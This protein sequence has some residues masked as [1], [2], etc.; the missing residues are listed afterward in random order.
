MSLAVSSFIGLWSGLPAYSAA[1]AR[2]AVR[3]VVAP[4]ASATS[5]WALG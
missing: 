3:I 2:G 1:S 5:T 4:T